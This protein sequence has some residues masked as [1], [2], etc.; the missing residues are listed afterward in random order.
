MKNWIVLLW[1]FD[2]S[3]FLLWRNEFILISACRSDY[4]KIVNVA[5]V[6]D[7]E[8]DCIEENGR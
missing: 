4:L 8:Y 7:G 1:L 3:L 5:D 2:P 6:E